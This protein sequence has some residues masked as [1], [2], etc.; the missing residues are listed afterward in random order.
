[1][2]K[3]KFSFILLCLIIAS[4]IQ[5][6]EVISVIG[7]NM[8]GAGGS[9]SFSSGQIAFASYSG[10]GGSIDE[11]V[12]QSFEIYITTGLENAKDIT[13]SSSVY[14]NPATEHIS[15]K[16]ND[17]NLFTKSTLIYQLFD[18]NAVLI[19]ENKISDTT[20]NINLQ[21]LNPSTYF[22]KII[23]DKTEKITYKI[24]KK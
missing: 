12:Q 2:K 6:Q 17:S 1:M 14:P 4:G 23:Q 10:T 13:L 20:T 7:G 3:K 22:L 16:I 21:N 18:I 19:Q 24:I 11:G 5:A 9:V 15:L 8:T